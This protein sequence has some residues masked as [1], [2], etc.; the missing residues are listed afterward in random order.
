MFSIL[1]SRISNDKPSPSARS[2]SPPRSARD[3]NFTILG[4][5]INLKFSILSFDI[6]ELLSIT[7]EN[8]KFPPD[9]PLKK[10][11]SD[12]RGLAKSE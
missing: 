8:N 7:D 9:N 5:L 4:A 3:N 11:N 10:L 2:A 1:A 6:L 12:K